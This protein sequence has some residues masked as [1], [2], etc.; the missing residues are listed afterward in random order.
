MMCPKCL[1]DNYIMRSEIYQSI[2][3]ERCPICKGI[4]LDRGELT[5]LVQSQQGDQADSLAYS[6]LSE[7]MDDVVARC[8]RC[9]R[10]MRDVMLLGNVKANQC[11]QC[12]AL[13]LDQGE[14]A[15]IQLAYR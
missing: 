8:P 4:F 7:I 1:D 10:N 11:Q 15:S 5:R 6:P 2:E 14:L 3:I 13:F 12:G 9:D